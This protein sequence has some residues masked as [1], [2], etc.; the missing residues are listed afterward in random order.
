MPSYHAAL[1]FPTKV[2]RR[3]LFW[4][5]NEEGGGHGNTE[6][7]EKREARRSAGDSSV[8]WLLD[9]DGRRLALVLLTVEYP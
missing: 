6:R 2:Y 7:E 3:L 5:H 4:E 8:C 1:E 9:S